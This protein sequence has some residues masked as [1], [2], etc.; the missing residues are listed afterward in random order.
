LESAA[1][2]VVEDGAISDSLKPLLN[3]LLWV[4]FKI[5]LILHHLR[6]NEMTSHFPHLE[7]TSD[8]SGSGFGLT[9]GSKLKPGTRIVLTMT[10]PDAPSRP[11]FAVG[12]VVRCGDAKSG[13]QAAAVQFIEISEADRERLIRF[14]FR[15]QRRE[16]ARRAGETKD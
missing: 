6:N 8:I 2:Q 5:D 7:T 12:E 16:L 9:P 3:V 13:E 11:L 4:D 10:L 15:Q 1:R 14:T